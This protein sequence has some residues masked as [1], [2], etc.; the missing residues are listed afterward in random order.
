MAKL[1]RE[2][3]AALKNIKASELRELESK[4]DPGLISPDVGKNKGK[5]IPLSELVLTDPSYFFW[6]LNSGAFRSFDSWLEFQAWEI[7]EKAKHILAPRAR[8]NDWTFDMQFDH[9][10]RFIDFQLVKKS[11]PLKPSGL[12]VKHLDLSL[13]SMQCAKACMKFAKR[14]REEFFADKELAHW[15]YQEFFDDHRNFDTS[16]RENHCPKIPRRMA[17]QRIARDEPQVERT[18]W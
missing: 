1:A 8:P 2:R 7:S 10:N 18:R 12:R 11:E 4:K 15:D 9:N 3:L 16:C 14:F 6:A 17:A 5:K 13:M